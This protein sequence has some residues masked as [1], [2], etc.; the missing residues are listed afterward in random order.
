MQFEQIVALLPDYL[1]DN[2][3]AEQ[4]LIVEQ[5]LTKSSEL[6]EI[7]ED[8]KGLNIAATTWQEESVPE[9]HRTAFLARQRKPAQSNWLNWV[10][11]A[12]SFAA[13]CLV[14]F[15]IEIV[16]SSDGLQIG[17]GTPTTSVA[18]EQRADEYLQRW[19]QNQ[20]AYV[21]QQLMSYENRQLKRD[22]QI[23]TSVLEVNLEHRKE[24]IKQLTTFFTQQRNRD[25][26]LTQEKYQEL[27]EFQDQDRQ[28][29]KQLYASLS[30]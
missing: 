2:L 19:E 16:T 6:N 17:F 23:M 3:S 25:L 8:L 1:D 20:Q 26:L 11:L 27:Y 15:R 9:W 24:D 29:I 7:L 22:Q 14:V 12:T 5:Q 28:D 21:T 18:F 10:S 30:D 13:I 4:R